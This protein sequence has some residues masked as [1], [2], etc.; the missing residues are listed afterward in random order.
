MGM[1]GQR[2][3]L[4]AGALLL[5]TAF[6]TASAQ[7]LADVPRDR[8]FITVGWSAGSPTLSAPNNGNW[9]SLGAELRNGMMFVNGEP[10][11]VYGIAYNNTVERFR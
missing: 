8:T 1:G 4:A 3:W 2:A 7:D 9:Y 5:G 10:Q 11:G 6:V